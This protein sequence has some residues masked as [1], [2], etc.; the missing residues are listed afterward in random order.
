MCN[1]AAL[2]CILFEL[3]SI[4]V[5]HFVTILCVTLWAPQPPPPQP[6]PPPGTYLYILYC[7]FL[8]IHPNDLGLFLFQRRDIKLQIDTKVNVLDIVE[9]LKK[10][11]NTFKKGE[12][13]N[14]STVFEGPVH[15]MRP[16][17]LIG[18]TVISFFVFEKMFP[19]KCA[20]RKVR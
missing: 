15:D 9:I 18:W 6:P 2:A 14:N 12:P 8:I 7:N 13:W 16:S 4:K 3:W 17:S 10:L 1:L 19:L 5:T 11:Q 20:Q